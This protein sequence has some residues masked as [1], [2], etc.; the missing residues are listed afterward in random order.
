MTIVELRPRYTARGDF[1]LEERDAFLEKVEDLEGV[2]LVNADAA[3]LCV[4]GDPLLVL[5]LVGVLLP[6]NMPPPLNRPPDAPFEDDA[7]ERCISGLGQ[8]CQQ[9]GW[10]YFVIFWSRQKSPSASLTHSLLSRSYS[11]FPRGL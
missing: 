10:N 11:S 9:Q 4:V 3:S 2:V 6:P 7:V 5:G 8:I 1:W